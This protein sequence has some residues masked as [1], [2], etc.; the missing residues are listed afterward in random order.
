MKVWS[1]FETRKVFSQLKIESERAERLTSEYG[2]PLWCKETGFRNTHLQ[3]ENNQQLVTL[4][5]LGN[6]SPVLNLLLMYLLNKL[7]KEH[8]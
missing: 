1:Q 8:L 5:C 2:E 6:V 3:L 4:N 7:L